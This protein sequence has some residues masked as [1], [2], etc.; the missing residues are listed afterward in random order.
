MLTVL[1]F[2]G[3]NL[4]SITPPS[5]HGLWHSVSTL[6]AQW[7]ALRL[8]SKAHKQL[9]DCALCAAQRFSAHDDKQWETLKTLER[10]YGVGEAVCM[11][12]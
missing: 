5:G 7:L 3:T 12:H 8:T 6:F 2:S 11:K 4:D 9:P 10:T 1:P